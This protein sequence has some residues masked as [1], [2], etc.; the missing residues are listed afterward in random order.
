MHQ[1]RVMRLFAAA[2]FLP[3]SGDAQR[4]HQGQ[5]QPRTPRR[6]PRTNGPTAL[7]GTAHHAGF[8]GRCRLTRHLPC[9]DTKPREQSRRQTGLRCRK[10]KIFQ[11]W[12]FLL[13]LRIRIGWFLLL[14]GRLFLFFCGRLGHLPRAGCQDELRCKRRIFPG[15]F[16]AT[17]KCRGGAGATQRKN[18]RTQGWNT[19]RQ[20][21]RAKGLRQIVRYF[22]IR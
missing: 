22:D 5:T 2:I 13:L 17:R 3:R 9:R 11:G 12:L 4:F 15:Y 8:A 19:K 1:R 7:G 20:G 6:R 21:C 18:R 16:R 14:L 10:H